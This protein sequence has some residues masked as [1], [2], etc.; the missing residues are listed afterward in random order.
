MKSVL[1]VCLIAE[2]PGEPVDIM[3]RIHKLVN[4]EKCDEL[5]DLINDVYGM[6][7]FTD[8]AVKDVR[9]LLAWKSDDQSK[10]Q[11]S[12]TTSPAKDRQVSAVEFAS[13]SAELRGA[14]EL[15]ST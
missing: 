6:P 10:S 13:I 9:T 14:R 7:V 2:V 8:Q 4:S 11:P 12:K 5:L 1:E 3:E 15:I